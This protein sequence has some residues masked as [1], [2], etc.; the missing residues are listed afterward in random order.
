[1]M[2]LNSVDNLYSPSRSGI[3][4]IDIHLP[5]WPRISF[6]GNH[7]SRRFLYHLAALQLRDLCLVASLQKRLDTWWGSHLSTGRPP[8]RAFL[9]RSLLSKLPALCNYFHLMGSPFVLPPRRK[10]SA[11]HQKRKLSRSRI[12]TCLFYDDHCASLH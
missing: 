12:G 5:P 4:I 10:R 6:R 8:V 1:M 9:Q 2:L 3:T 7:A 11:L